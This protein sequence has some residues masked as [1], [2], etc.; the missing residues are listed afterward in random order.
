MHAEAG[1]EVTRGREQM[2]LQEVFEA[3]GGKGS[4]ATREIARDL[5]VSQRQ[6]QR[7]L[8]GPEARERRGMGPKSTRFFREL[9]DR[10]LRRAGERAL[11]E[12][13]LVIEG[14]FALC[15]QGDQEG[16]E[17]ELPPETIV[18]DNSDWLDL[19]AAGDCDGAARMLTDAM[20]EAYGIE[21]GDV[22]VC[23]DDGGQN[24]HASAVS[25]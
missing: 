11:R 24:L 20:L 19:Y 2:T 10:E 4:H 17:R 23:D 15:Y 18:E 6:V 25:A 7:M 21:A 8:A 5:D 9:S 12:R 13:G 16:D 14:E 1:R 3:R 22:D